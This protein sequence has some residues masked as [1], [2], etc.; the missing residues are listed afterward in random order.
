MLG[1]VASAD[2]VTY[3]DTG[4]NS[5]QQT[6]I[7]NTNDS[8]VSTTSNVHVVNFNSQVA[9]S[10]A[11]EAKGDT[12]VGSVSS[13]NASN[14][15]STTTAVTVNSTATGG[16]GGSGGGTSGGGKGGGTGGGSASGPVGG[17]GGGS[18]LGAATGGSG[19]GSAVLPEVGASTPM[20][21]S[22]L[23][24][25]Y[26]AGNGGSLAAGSSG[27]DLGY[28]IPA[29]LLSALAGVG[30]VIRQKRHLQLVKV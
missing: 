24:S 15:N 29:F 7:T 21:L 4:S 18:A 17:L 6:T 30:M 20:D 25:L 27:L 5:N 1:G 28:L 26:T 13:G 14:T 3:T 12:T 22:A 23:R 19:G 10:G 11:V 16:A 2:S 9:K 8:T